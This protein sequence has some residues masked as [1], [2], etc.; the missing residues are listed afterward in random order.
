MSIRSLLCESFQ[1][2]A[3]VNQP[4]VDCEF[5]VNNSSVA[6]MRGGEISVDLGQ[7]ISDA[8]I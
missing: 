4:A 7:R 3:V 2:A 8:V 5:F 6:D 1:R